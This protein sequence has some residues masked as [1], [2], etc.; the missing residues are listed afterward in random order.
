MPAKKKYPKETKT[1]Y[2]K[3]VTKKGPARKK[4][5]MKASKKYGK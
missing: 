4:A 5:N 2:A 3:R 1:E